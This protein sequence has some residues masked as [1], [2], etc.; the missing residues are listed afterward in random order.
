MS[1]FAC[2]Y[3]FWFVAQALERGR[4]RGA[5]VRHISQ[6]AACARGGWV[7]VPRYVSVGLSVRSIE[8]KCDRGTWGVDNPRVDLCDGIIPT[9]QCFIYRFSNP[10]TPRIQISPI[11][12]SLVDFLCGF[13]TALELIFA[14]F[15]PS[16]FHNFA[17]D[18]SVVS[19]F[20]FHF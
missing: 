16:F 17:S 9:L 10:N 2:L 4:K 13:Q 19:K 7:L 18:H 15:L 20:S 12:S 8:R 6:S 14:F 1:H 5:W 3:T 11:F